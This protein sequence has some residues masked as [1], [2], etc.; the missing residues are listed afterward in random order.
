[1]K[2]PAASR[3][4]KTILISRRAA[5]GR[6]LLARDQ[7]AAHPDFL[8]LSE[9]ER[10]NALGLFGAE[11]RAI[12]E[13]HETFESVPGEAVPLVPPRIRRDARPRE[14]EARS[15]LVWDVPLL[16]G[17]LF[18]VGVVFATKSAPVVHAP[19][20]VKAAATVPA[21]QPS[22]RVETARDV[23]NAIAIT[24]VAN[25]TVTA[26][27]DPEPVR[28]EAAIEREPRRVPK[29]ADSSPAAVEPVLTSA[30]ALEPPPLDGL[31]LPASLAVAPRSAPA[32][33]LS[34]PRVESAAP[35]LPAPVSS[36]E[37]A[38]QAVLG[39][40]RAAY[41]GLDVGAARAVWPSVDGKALSKAFERLAEQ[42]LVFD[43][44]DIAVSSGA[45]ALASCRGS[46]S[47]VP[48]VGKAR[49]ADQREWQF[50][51]SKVDDA[52]LIDTVS[53]R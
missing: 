27:D 17:V 40:Y 32:V 9:E 30:P 41:Q 24:P 52:W 22:P 37:T 45:R 51:L 20:Q 35:V 33:P 53:A 25:G 34:S 47:Y 10:R 50:A 5:I 42:Q 43:S 12:R 36:P 39:Q 23:A 44:C 16:V 18:V 49:R 31:A 38:I 26:A 4:C 11:E 14:R 7:G 48:R 13:Q 8:S 15:A 19:P 6:A 29:I 28:V 2:W 21:E 3:R 46:V 1:M